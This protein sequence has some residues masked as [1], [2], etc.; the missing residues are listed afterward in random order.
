MGR[1][2]ILA[3]VGTLAVVAALAIADPPQAAAAGCDP[4]GNPV[5][6]DGDAGTPTWGEPT[7][8]S[9]DQ[10]PGSGANVCIEGEGTSVTFDSGSASVATIGVEPGASLSL[11]AGTLDIT[12]PD[13][14][15]IANLSVFGGAVSGTVRAPSRARSRCTAARCRG[16]PPPR[17]RPVLSC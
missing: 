15:T 9:G 11:I 16:V 17:S 4:A 7:N 8:W 3:G 1:S 6:W 2:A 10:V 14:S 5:T 12:G 13:P